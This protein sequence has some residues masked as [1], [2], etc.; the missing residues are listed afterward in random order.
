MKNN[1]NNECSVG[2]YRRYRTHTYKYSGVDY[3]RKHIEARMRLSSLFAGIDKDIE[4]V[5]FKLPS[6]NLN[7]LLIQY[8]NNYGK[9]ASDYA[10]VTYPKWKSGQV[11]MSGLVAERLLNLIPPFLTEGERFDLIKKLRTA[12]ITKSSRSLTTSFNNWKEDLSPAIASLVEL[13]SRFNLPDKIISR[14]KWLTDGNSSSAMKLLAAAEIE[15]AQVR[16]EYLELEF[17]RIEQLISDV[18]YTKYVVHKILLPQGTIE[19]TIVLPKKSF[20]HKLFKRREKG[21]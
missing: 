8:G 3:A 17:K 13:N 1:L 9:K 11:K 4:N 15:E 21:K 18:K 10:R 20:W 2:R 19:I 7:S 5:F 14:A 6:S 12:Y 16:M